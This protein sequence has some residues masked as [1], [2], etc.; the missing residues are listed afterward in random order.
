MARFAGLGGLLV[1]W[2]VDGKAQPDRTINGV[3]AGLVAITAGCDAV[4]TQAAIVIGLIAGGLVTVSVNVIERVFKLDDVV[5]AV[6]VH[7]T[8]GVFGVIMAGALAME[9]KLAA[10][11]R[12]DQILVQ[13]EGAAIHFVWTFG[14]TLAILSAIRTVVPLRVPMDVEER[15]LDLVEHGVKLERPL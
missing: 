13:V 9:D 15:G 7:G 2:Y 1:G 6:S 11:S 10:G 12:V 14:V 4:G 5:G 3:L 8:C